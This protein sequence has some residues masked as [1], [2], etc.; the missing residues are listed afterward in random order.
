M[1]LI[2]KQIYTD[3]IFMYVSQSI[4]SNQVLLITFNCRKINDTKRIFF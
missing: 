1:Y 3:I 4:E 2:D